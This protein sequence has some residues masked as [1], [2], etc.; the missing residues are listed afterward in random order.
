MVGLYGVARPLARVEDINGVKVVLLSDGKDTSGRLRDAMAI[1]ERYDPRW[2]RHLREKVRRMVVV[3]VGIPEFRPVV[4]GCY[5]PLALI[6]ALTK[7]ELAVLLVHEA[8]HARLHEWGVRPKPPNR[9]RIEVV[10]V[11]REVAFAG[12]IPGVGPR[13]AAEAS[14]RLETRWWEPDR[15]AERMKALLSK[16]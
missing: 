5:I 9:E 2:L 3:E 15:H 8:T 16:L 4:R 10:C 7:E 6:D 14:D 11:G 12:K 13:L 1:I